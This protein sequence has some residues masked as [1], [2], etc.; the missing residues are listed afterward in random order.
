MNVV[1]NPATDATATTF[2]DDLFDACSDSVIRGLLY[3]HYKHVR[4]AVVQMRVGDKKRV[5]KLMCEAR[6]K[7]K[8][9][10]VEA[11]DPG[12]VL[13][14]YGISVGDFCVWQVLEGK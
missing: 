9:D 8:S 5:Y 13:P 10:F 11:P 2:A 14:V 12:N 1:N 7:S 6:N 3:L 4:S